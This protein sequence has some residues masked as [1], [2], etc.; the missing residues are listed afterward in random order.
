ME[1]CRSC[2]TYWMLVLSPC[3]WGKGRKWGSSEALPAEASCLM[4]SDV[5]RLNQFP[6]IQIAQKLVTFIY[7][8]IL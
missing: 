3:P 1:T 7:I 6:G 2:G 5:S 8:Y 4:D